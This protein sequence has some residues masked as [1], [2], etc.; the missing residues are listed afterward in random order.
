MAEP[1]ADAQPATT[2]PATAPATDAAA[3]QAAVQLA[4]EPLKVEHA[5]EVLRLKANAE[6]VIG[7]K[8][9]ETEKRQALQQQVD[10]LALKTKAA[11]K[12]HDPDDF[13]KAVQMQVEEQRAILDKEQ[14]DLTTASQDRISTLES[15]LEAAKAVAHLATVGQEMVESAL[16]DRR[17]WHPGAGPRLFSDVAPFAHPVETPAGTEL[18]LKTA[19]GTWVPSVKHPGQHMTLGE[20]QTMARAGKT[21]EGLPTISWYLMDPSRSA[22][23]QESAAEAASQPWGKLTE[24]QRMDMWSNDPTTAEKLVV[25]D[26][27]R[28]AAASVS[29]GA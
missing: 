2:D 5:A 27:E 7:E 20:Y 23:T 13:A 18:R 9:A 14:A 12:G 26:A 4:I 15:E 6:S 8:R 10:A 3:I 19:S 22:N 16:G 21:V 17:V 1:T 24:V 29:A 28:Q 25:A 11:E